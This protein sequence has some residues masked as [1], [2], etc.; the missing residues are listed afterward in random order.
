[1]SNQWLEWAKRIQ[2]ISQAGLSFSKDIYDI[3][4][5][6][7]LR[8]ISLEIMSEYTELEMNKLRDLFANET[9]YQTPKVDVRG[10]VFKNNQ[11]LMVKE[12]ID[13]KWALPGGFCDIGLSPSENVV[14]EI[15][16]ESGYDVIPIKL[17]ALLDKNKHPH[18]PEPY[19][20][21]KIFILCEIIGGEA[22]IG[23][24]TNNIQFFSQHNLPQ[25]ST[26]RNTESQ[27]NTLFEFLRTPEKETLFD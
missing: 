3:E 14:K 16:E 26:N 7:E 22:T 23:I 24:E 2:A 6:K 27:I 5:Y 9:G 18:P 17:I 8:K 1:M 13:D 20:Y 10:V 11:I 12:N 4:R 21:Y 19:H 15:K 25:L